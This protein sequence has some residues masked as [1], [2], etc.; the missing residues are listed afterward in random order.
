VW[1]EE[2]EEELSA[3]GYACLCHP[4]RDCN[5]GQRVHKE[6][7]RLTLHALHSGG[8]KQIAG[9]RQQ[10]ARV[11]WHRAGYQERMLSQQ[12]TLSQGRIA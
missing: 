6:G 2:Q 5:Q 9:V 3:L 1:H 12:L 8:Y 4:H 7:G 10:I 11:H